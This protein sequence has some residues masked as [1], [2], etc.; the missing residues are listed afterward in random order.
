MH[1]PEKQRKKLNN[2]AWQGIFIG[3]KGKNLYRIY[4]PLTGKIH[5]TQDVNIDKELLYDKSEVNSWE[6]ANTEW[7]NINNS[8]FANLL[9]FDEDETENNT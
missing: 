8:S 4:H 1:I 9:E 6:F 3:C 5:K 2:K 7:E